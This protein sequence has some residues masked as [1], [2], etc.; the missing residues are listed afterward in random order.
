MRIDAYTQ[1][2]QLYG[3][4]KTQKVQQEAKIGF[5]DQLEISSKGKDYQ[6]AKNA[7]GN[8]ADIREEVV[9]PLKN[10]VNAGI[11]EVSGEQ[12]ARKLFEKY[13]SS[14]LGSF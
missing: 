6:T 4:K 10:A 13:N 3:T 8:A 7:V 12:F 5:K 11:Y 9:A 14:F 1:V 2:Q